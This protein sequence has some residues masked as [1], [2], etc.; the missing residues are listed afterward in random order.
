[1][2]KGRMKCTVCGHIYNPV[3]GDE[4]VEPGTAFSDIPEEWKCPICGASKPKFTE[5][6]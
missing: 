6:D 3:K 1:M 4:G 2:S 5:V